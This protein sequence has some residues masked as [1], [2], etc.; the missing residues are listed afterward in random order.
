[1]DKWSHSVPL[2]RIQQ[3]R[4]GEGLKTKVGGGGRNSEIGNSGLLPESTGFIH[5]LRHLMKREVQ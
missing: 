3:N 4:S 5:A 1:M 2:K